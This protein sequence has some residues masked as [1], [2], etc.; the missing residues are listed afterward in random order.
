MKVLELELQKAARARDL[1]QRADFRRWAEA[2]LADRSGRAELVIRIVGRR[3]AAELNRRYRNQRGP[4]NVLSFPWEAPPGAA[5]DLLG[6]LVICAPVVRQEAAE[7]GKEARAHWAHLVVHG[8]LHLLGHDHQVENEATAMEA[9][10][11]GILC[12][13]GFPDPYAEDHG[14]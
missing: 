2:A 5:S 10:E 11:T 6:D 14:R 8:V 13:L 4:T 9:L 3:E 7:Q 1:P 12:A